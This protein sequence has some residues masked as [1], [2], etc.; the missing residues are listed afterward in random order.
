MGL[1]E[2]VQI[3]SRGAFPAGF[4]GS[5]SGKLVFPDSE[6]KLA[7]QGLGLGGEMVYGRSIVPVIVLERTVL[8]VS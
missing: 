2:L 6:I 3:Y 5:G 1:C 8:T 4:L 7:R